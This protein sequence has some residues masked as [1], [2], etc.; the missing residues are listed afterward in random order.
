MCVSTSPLNTALINRSCPCSF[1][2]AAVLALV[3]S[4]SMFDRLLT[5][6]LLVQVGCSL[7]RYVLFHYQ[8]TNCFLTRVTQLCLASLPGLSASSP[9]LR[10]IRY[11]WVRSGFVQKLALSFTFPFAMFDSPHWPWVLVGRVGK[12][13]RLTVAARFPSISRHDVDQAALTRTSVR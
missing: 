7:L 6:C 8:S 4:R 1:E 10:S 11:F 5:Q 2:T 13:E 12:S 9:E 3:V